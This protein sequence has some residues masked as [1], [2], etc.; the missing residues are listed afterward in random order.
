MA[1]RLSAI[2]HDNTTELK[3]HKA[4]YRRFTRKKEHL[5]TRSEETPEKTTRECNLNRCIF[6]QDEKKDSLRQVQTKDT[7]DRIKQGCQTH[8][9]MSRRIPNYLDPVAAGVK[10]HVA[11]YM[12]FLRTSWTAATP[13]QDQDPVEE[14]IAQITR[15]MKKQACEDPPSAV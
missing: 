2:Q 3:Y 12:H 4:C 7:A 10:Y 13:K 6:C 9:T 8:P 14:A 15:A 1:D 11:C 5:R